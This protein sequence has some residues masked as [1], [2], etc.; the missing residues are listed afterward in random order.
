MTKI[1]NQKIIFVFLIVLTILGTFLIQAKTSQAV[2]EI[3]EYTVLAPLPGT[4]KGSGDC[5]GT[6]C[7]A[8]LAS[9]IPGLFNLII[10]L[11]AVVAVA[12]IIYG[13]FKYITTDAILGKEEGKKLIQNAIYGLIMISVAWLILFTINPRILE[14][15]LNIDAITVPTG[16]PGE[17]RDSRAA[18]DAVLAACPACELEPIPINLSAADIARLSCTTCTP[19]STPPLTL[20]GNSQPNATPELN[21]RLVALRRA[22]GNNNAWNVSEAYPPTRTHENNCHFNGTCVDAIL[23]EAGRTTANI[24]S[25]AT[26]ASNSNLRAVYEVSTPEQRQALI[27]Q[28]VTAEIQVVSGVSPHFS[29]YMR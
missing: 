25:F 29:V 13:G 6:D 20:N 22:T 23:P 27:N 7:K 5:V 18:R 3:K 2:V 9:Y 15:K 21:N 28:G 24:N 16:P 14:F 19:L 10:G 1:L 26:N 12:Y 11:S 4:T 8:D 17:L